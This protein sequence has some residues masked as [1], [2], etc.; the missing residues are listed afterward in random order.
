MLALA[1]VRPRLS[2]PPSPPPRSF[3]LFVSLYLGAGIMYNRQQGKEGRDA[4]PNVEFWTVTLPAL[5]WDGVAF[6]TAKFNEFKEAKLK[7]GA[8][9]LLGG[10]GEVDPDDPFQGKGAPTA[11]T[12]DL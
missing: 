10:G 9:G 12:D 5:V 7:N 8:G 11:R 4:I 6:S 3:F 1:F 2:S